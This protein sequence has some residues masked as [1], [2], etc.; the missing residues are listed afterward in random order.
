[1]EAVDAV[2]KVFEGQPLPSATDGT[3]RFDRGKIA[4]MTKAE[5]TLFLEKVEQEQEVE[6]GHANA[7]IRLNEDELLER[8][9]SVQNQNNITQSEKLEAGQGR[10]SLDI[11]METGTGKT[12]VYIKTM[13]ELN[14][15]YGW[16]KFII[17]VPSVAIREGVKK[18]FE[19]TE[20]HFM[21]QYGKKARYF[22]YDSSNLTKIDEF[23]TSNEIHVMIINNQAFAKSLNEDKNVAGR[24]GDKGAL[25]I[26]GRPDSFGSRRPID[27]IAQTNPILIL[28]EPQKLAGKAT[29]KS[30]EQFKPLFS[31]NYS[32]T[33]KT[34]HN[35][36]YVLDALDAY[37]K[38]LVKKIQ[39]K[40]I[41]TTN[42]KGID[43]YLYCD[44]V[45]VAKNK[46]P[47]MRM[48]FEV[49]RSNGPK[50]EIHVLNVGDNLYE[51]SKGMNQYKG[52][53]VSD[54][55]PHGIG[56]VTFTNGEKIYGGEAVGDVSE[57]D[58][59]RI[60]IRET[61]HSHFEKEEKLFKKGIKTLSLFFIDEVAK[62]RVYNEAGETE[63]GEYGK[64][65]EEE[66]NKIFNG[67][68][69][70][71]FND[72][73]IQHLKKIAS[74][75]SMVHT[76][77]FSIDKK[78]HA[79][80]SKVE[81]GQD[82][83][84]DVSAYDLIMKNKEML[85]DM[86]NP[87]RFIF[88][89]SALREGW[90][91]P[92]VFQICTLKHSNSDVNKRQEV[93]RG[94]RICVNQQGERMDEEACGPAVHDVNLL[95]VI[96][97]ESYTDFV[98]GLQSDIKDNLY[99]RPTKASEEYFK[100][101]KL[102]IDGKEYNID[103][104]QAKKINKYLYKYDYIDDDDKVT[105][106]YRE[107]LAAGTLVPVPDS[108]K[109][110]EPAI[111]VLVQSIF[112]ESVLKKMIENGKET[113]IKENPLNDN[114]KRDEFQ[115]L[116]NKIN[117]QYAYKVSFD[118]KELI[119]NSVAALNANLTVTPVKYIV[120]VGDQDGNV[121]RH[122]YEQGDAFKVTKRETGT[123][124][125]HHE[126]TIKYDLVHEIASRTT[127]TRKT[128]AEILKGIWNTKFYMF[129][130]NPEE[131]IRKVAN[132]INEQKAALT[133][134]H[135]TYN[136]TDEVF[137]SDIFTAEVYRESFD[138]AFKAKNAIQEY[139]FTDGSAAKSI[140]RKFVEA[141]DVSSEVAVYAKLP[142]SF[143][144]P[145]PM[146]KYSPDWAI[147]FKE[148]HVKH[149]YF[150]AETK[151]SLSSLDLRPI[152][153]AKINCAKKLFAKLS[154]GDV[155]YGHVTNYQ[156]LMD[157]VLDRNAGGKKVIY[158]PEYRESHLKAADNPKQE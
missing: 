66:Y 109:N 126:S 14:K 84:S 113:T 65:F 145:T 3:Y 26:Y 123:L 158:Y 38:K 73:Y 51:L 23:A 9:H 13:F 93:G 44:G 83:S 124:K 144:I 56:C 120:T 74:D 96:A 106:K 108:L 72:P 105:D 37:N 140:E 116:W 104:D 55:D 82:T 135:I 1:T 46:P 138:K 79:V 99:N 67:K 32:A 152:E 101:R 153:K 130:E 102:V 132:T 143:Y 142:R 95:T 57:I 41:E 6:L 90:D 34:K 28:D 80:D 157:I 100:G 92:N 155:H 31:V 78:G 115:K 75:V 147:A 24:G 16:K 21:E 81:R 53:T 40:G 117:H 54:I 131:F 30:M 11:E 64:I 151:G 68:V 71:L 87:V 156:E 85:L 70:E 141:L 39:V 27:V 112:D 134:E 17:I 58:K 88:S 128:V 150:V 122:Q 49:M 136:T 5:Q 86:N 2:V 129:K 60:Q 148:G 125:E 8:I 91:N 114:F 36:V 63:L 98:S 118:S 7:P 89:H 110:I 69:Q 111:H 25:I 43:S 42:F 121:Q 52:Y 22:I 59:R 97:S 103:E 10:C 154:N 76:G 35:L 94:M 137:E 15:H 139:V 127:L 107:D 61:I 119:R 48:E 133:V 62:Y 45:V 50:R 19:I 29:Q 12:Y 18:T 149:L 146:G 20:E 77:Y 4:Q 33:H 47:R